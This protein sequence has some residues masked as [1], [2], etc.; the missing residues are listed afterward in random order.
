M[1]TPWS[2]SST[3]RSAAWLTGSV[4]VVVY[5]VL[6][7]AAF[8]PTWPFDGSRLPNG[9]F[10]DPVQ[11]VWFLAW[12][13]F[14]LLH[15]HDPFF[16]TAI[17]YPTGA[18]LAANTSVPFLGLLG[19]PI[20]L[21]LGPIATFNVLLRLAL[22]SSAASTYFVLGAWCRSRFARFIGGVIFGFGPYVATHVRSEGHLN[23]VFLPMLPLLAWCFGAIFGDDRRSPVRLGVLLGFVAAVQLLIS[24]EMLSDAAIV[25]AVVLAVLGLAD[26]KRARRQARRAGSAM[27]AAL[28]TFAVLATWPIVEILGGRDHLSG[29]VARV[30]HLQSFRNDLLAPFLPTARQLIA[31]AGA[32]RGAIVSSAP[33]VR[34]GGGS[35]IGAYLGIPLVLAVVAVV[36]WRRREGVVLA[37]G[38]VGAVAAVG[39]L[40]DRLQIDGHLTGVR[41]PEA[42]LTHVPLLDN[43]VP[44][45]FSAIVLLGAAALVALGIDRSLLVAHT[46]TTPWQRR[47][48]GVV[49]TGGVVLVVLPIVPSSAY[50]VESTAVSSSVA[51]AIEREVPAGSVALTSPYA[52]PPFTEAMAWAALDRINFSI[53]GGYATVPGAKGI[54]RTSAPL[55]DPPEVQ[56]YLS[57][58]EAGRSR[59]YPPA[60]TLSLT[61]L[62]A[63]V[64]RY[65]VNEVIFDSSRPG[66][67][68]VERLFRADFGQPVVDDGVAFW[69]TGHNGACRR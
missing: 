69:R 28:G 26:P 62:C 34:A 67:G 47:L 35:E 40:G 50:S 14:A 41:L 29:T 53:V 21:S 32:V 39:S 3:A 17:D 12:T 45:R 20:T 43:T 24:P 15:G 55:L 8:A 18:N 63:F 66:D 2:L 4:V 46:S 22:A 59:H 11:M 42:L 5:V 33:A 58:I 30:S 36:I 64:E 48:R 25:A 60:T 9:P 38:L 1:A 7:C 65:G 23:L 37:F 61:D 6:G 54:A 27:A 49:I 13:P 57:R 16:T 56:E 19:A 51:A 31:P 44:A 10:G 68:S 52:D